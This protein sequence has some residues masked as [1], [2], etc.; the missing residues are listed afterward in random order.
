[1]VHVYIKV[2]SLLGAKSQKTVTE[3]H[4]EKELV[5]HAA[6][7]CVKHL[8]EVRGHATSV[9]PLSTASFKPLIFSTGGQMSKETS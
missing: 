6:K 4:V 1:M 9:C 5:I 3:V 7:R 8:D 2:V